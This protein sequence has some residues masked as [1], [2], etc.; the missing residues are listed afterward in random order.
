M[1]AEAIDN[2]GNRKVT[3]EESLA[4]TLMADLK[5]SREPHDGDFKAGDGGVITVTTGG[6]ADKVVIRFPEELA[7]LKP[8]LDHEYIYEWP[9]AVKTEVYEFNLPLDTLAGGYIIEIEAWKNGKKL[10]TELQLPIRTNGSII[11]ELRTRIQDNG[12]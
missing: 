4:F 11:D 6:Y 5:R 7:A 2:V 12:V 1:E 10:T 9:T 8:E 3:D